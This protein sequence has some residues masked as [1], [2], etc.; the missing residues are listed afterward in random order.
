[1]E[2]S[3]L[4]D[5]ENNWAMMRLCLYKY[6]CH[7]FRRLED[8]TLFPVFTV[9]VV[10]SS[11]AAGLTLLSAKSDHFNTSGHAIHPCLEF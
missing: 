3:V 1:M 4:L 9:T 7:R 8:K 5:A 6:F 10:H 11:L 2:K